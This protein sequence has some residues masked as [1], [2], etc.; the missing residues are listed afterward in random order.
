MIKRL[1]CALAGMCLMFSMTAC[2]LGQ[3]MEIFDQSKI[4]L[5]QTEDL[6]NGEDIAVVETSEGNFKMRFFPSEAPKTVENFINLAQSGYFDGQ[7]ISRIEKVEEQDRIKGRLIAGSGKPIDQEGETIFEKPVRP[8]IS[9]NLGT[10]PGAVVAYTPS[11]VMDSR[12]Y[13]V[14]SCKVHKEELEEIERNNYPKKLVDL[15]R[16]HGGYPEDWLHRSVF[17]QVVE[18]MDVVDRIIRETPNTDADEITD[19]EIIRVTIEKYQE[20]SK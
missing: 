5:L 7:K 16:K 15:F 8:E 10:I 9:Y 3:R 1:S 12:F 14:G 18:G 17:A 6:I 20:P 4:V 2:S 19:I 11:D 13:I